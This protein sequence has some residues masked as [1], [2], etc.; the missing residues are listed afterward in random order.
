MTHVYPKLRVYPQRRTRSCS[1]ISAPDGVH[2]GSTLTFVNSVAW[3]DQVTLGPSPNGWK[4]CIA[5][6]TSATS[7]LDGYKQV[8]GFAGMTYTHIGSKPGLKDVKITTGHNL[9]A[10]SAVNYPGAVVNSDADAMAVKNLLGSYIS[11]R[12]AWRGGNFIAEFAETVHMLAHP[13]KSIYNRTWSFVGTVGKLKK[14][15]RRDP[16]RYGRLLGGAWLAYAFGIKPLVDDVADAQAAINKLR[17]SLGAFDLLPIMGSGY[18]EAVQHIFT[19]AAVPNCPYAQFN[20]DLF[21]KSFVKYYGYIRARPMNYPQIAENFGV[22]FTDILPAV[23]E[24]V[25]WSFLVDYFV[26]VSEML[27]SAK[28][29]FADLA[30]L[31]KGTKVALESKSSDIF[32]PTSAGV[33]NGYTVNCGGGGSVSKRHWKHRTAVLDIP[34]PSF[35]FRIPGIGSTKWANVAALV[36]QIAGSKPR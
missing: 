19:N 11:Q 12:N 10:G 26:N 35:H 5:A 36:A 22:G 24:A 33:A 17:D 23:W 25:P 21:S 28:F 18:A 13:L 1:T 4:A 15:Y 30:W 6:G 16:H 34:Y 3:S 20:E 2:F 14:V 27:D 8:H 7:V 9:N 32:G 31:N 29:A